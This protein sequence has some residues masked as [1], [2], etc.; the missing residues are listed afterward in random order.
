MAHFL[1]TDWTHKIKTNP[2]AN[3]ILNSHRPKLYRMKLH[4]IT[5]HP[6]EGSYMS[7]AF[8]S[9]YSTVERD[10]ILTAEDFKNATDTWAT[11]PEYLETYNSVIQADEDGDEKKGDDDDVA[12][13]VRKIGDKGDGDKGKIKGKEKGGIVGVAAH[14]VAKKKDGD[15]IVN[16]EVKRKATLE[17]AQELDEDEYELALSYEELQGGDM[18]ANTYVNDYINIHHPK[19]RM[20]YVTALTGRPLQIKQPSVFF[21]DV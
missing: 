4:E 7:R 15:G 3:M 10:E 14:P 5:H 20:D 1:T 2:V 18:W 19:I 12:I 17:N 16:V 8:V 6:E 21:S 13:V 11:I 9:K